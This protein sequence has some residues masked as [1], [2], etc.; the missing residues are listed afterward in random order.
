[1]MTNSL[2]AFFSVLGWIAEHWLISGLVTIYL[3][4]AVLLLAKG[5]RLK[6]ASTWPFWLLAL[7]LWDGT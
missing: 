5:M 6:A 1:M 3:L 4:G 7:A 2:L